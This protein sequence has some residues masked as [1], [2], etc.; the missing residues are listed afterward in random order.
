MQNTQPTAQPTWVETHN[1]SRGSSTL[2]T[3]WPSASSTSRRAEPSSLGCSERS[4]ARP[5]QIGQQ[6]RQCAAH[7]ERQEVLGPAPTAVLRQRL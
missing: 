2:S 4:R 7:V 3:V 5:C 1:P 6:R